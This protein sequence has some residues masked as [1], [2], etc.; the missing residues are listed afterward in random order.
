VS[1]NVCPVRAHLDDPDTL[2]M[3]HLLFLAWGRRPAT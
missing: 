2:V 3:H 1:L